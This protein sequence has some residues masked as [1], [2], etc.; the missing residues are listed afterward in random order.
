MNKLQRHRTRADRPLSTRRGRGWR[1]AAAVLAGAAGLAAG[2]AAAQAPGDPS[3]WTC[4]GALTARF[5]PVDPDG[6]S[7]YRV[8]RS[9]R[10]PG[11]LAEAGWIT[12]PLSAGEAFAGA[13]PSVRRALVRLYGGR[14]VE[15]TRGWRRLGDGA[16]TLESVTLFSPAPD[17]SVTR[18]V[19]GT[20][21][22]T[23]R[24]LGPTTVREAPPNPGL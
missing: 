9:D 16:G 12:E 7:R 3:E 2:L 15:V 10:R 14:R 8:C 21:I 17:D 13:P 6:A 4:P 11:E 23:S 22:L 20:L 5:A 1:V 24:T 19:P 18:L